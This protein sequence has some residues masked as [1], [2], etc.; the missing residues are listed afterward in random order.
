MANI[1]KRIAQ[2]GKISFRVK[3][4]LKAFP[5]QTAT[6]QR[7]TDAR[8]W[9]QQIETS[10]REGRHFK[11]TEAKRHTLAQTIDRYTQKILSTQFKKK[12][13]QLTQLHWWKETLCAYTLAEVTPALLAEQRDKLL[14][15][16]TKRKKLRTPAT[17]NR[18]L[19]AL[20]HVFTVAIK[21]WQWIEENPLLKITK[22]KEPR[23]RVRFLSDEERQ[24][25]LDICKTSEN[26]ILYMVVV[27]ALSTG[28]RRM[29]LLGLHWK[30]VDLQR[31]VIILHETK[32]G[33]RR[34]L[35]LSGHALELM[36]QH[37]KVRNLNFD[38]VF[39]GKNLK[40]PI[41]IRS[42]WETALKRA[43]IANFRFHDLRHS[44]AS[45]LAMNG[46]SLSEISEIL[47]HK[48]LQMVKRYAH[49]SEAHTSKVVAKMNKKI[50]NLPNN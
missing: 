7:L 49:L 24:H 21:E 35:T 27:M 3:V 20:S 43:N 6:F 46:A 36:K 37:E 17:V 25:L 32:N 16:E 31:G 38:L 30:D 26:T 9:A 40:N 41:D 29:E 23:G 44:A 39:P 13:N 1:E 12:R 47:G 33:E 28:A 10:L 11:T 48:T 5:T 4:R 34:V 19:A 50:F 14:E 18:Y 8:K 45:Y 22:P 2:D 42:T 15:E